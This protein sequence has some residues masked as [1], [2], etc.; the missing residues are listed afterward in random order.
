MIK[1]FSQLI[2]VLLLTMLAWTKLYSLMDMRLH[3]RDLARWKYKMEIV[4]NPKLYFETL[5]VGD[6]AT[7]AGI[8]PRYLEGKQFNMS[9]G[10]GTPVDAYFYLSGYLKN[11]KLP[12]KLVVGFTP[13]GFEE[14]GEF[15]THALMLNIFSFKE[16]FGIGKH[17]DNLEAI[18]TKEYELPKTLS[19]NLIENNLMRYVYYYELLA[20]QCSLSKYQ[21]NLLENLYIP[22]VY[23]IN[24][25]RYK[26]LVKNPNIHIT[27]S[28]GKNNIKN[29]MVPLRFNVSKINDIYMRKIIELAKSK[30]IQ[31]YLITP[32]Y[33]KIYKKDFANVK[34]IVAYYHQLASGN[35]LVHVYPE[36][37]GYSYEDFEDSMHLT[38]KG[39]AVF[40]K[41]VSDFILKQ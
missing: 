16:L 14:R 27:A 18:G 34:D 40:S 10:G 4:D 2:V 20:I 19:K 12:K 5:I 36:F 15:Y 1:F 35:P 17:I 11:H 41:V 25:E 38:E 13:V 39:A 32:P 29:P 7:D 26:E 21:I 33:N 30:N 31:I 3:I 28:I 9:L 37:L 24:N 6:S 23:R 8:V 22:H